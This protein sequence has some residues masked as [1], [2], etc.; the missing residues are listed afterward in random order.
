[1]GQSTNGILAYGYDLGG[2]EGWKLQGLGEYD[3]LP[4]LDWYDPDNEEG[5]DL[6]SAAERRL[7]VEI[8]G[9]TETDW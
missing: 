7:L 8:A 1:M 9:F 5:D 2:E 6:Q 3:E 4:A